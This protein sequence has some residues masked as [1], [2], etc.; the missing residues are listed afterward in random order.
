MDLSRIRDAAAGEMELLHPATS[1]KLGVFIGMHGPESEPR[2]RWAL[3]RQRELRAGLKR[4]GSLDLGDPSADKENEINYLLECVTSWRQEVKLPDGK[5]DPDK[6]GPFIE[7][8]GEQVL[9]SGDNAYKIFTSQEHAWIRKQ[10]LGQL[11]ETANFIK[12][13]STTSA[14]GSSGVS[15]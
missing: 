14:P 4:T 15:A 7:F 6:T 2:Q 12:D 5:P 1:A 10:V 13:S 8:A 3:K 11:N 9:F